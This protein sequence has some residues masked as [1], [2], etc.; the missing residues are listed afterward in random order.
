LKRPLWL[1][2]ET[3]ALVLATVDSRFAIADEANDPIV[4]T[5][6][7]AI[8]GYFAGPNAIFKGIPFAEPPLGS[9]RW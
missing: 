7:G 5:D 9:L 2:V 8:R 4:Q 6:N 1:A 3:L